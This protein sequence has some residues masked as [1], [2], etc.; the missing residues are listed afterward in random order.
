MDK[1]MVLPLESKDFNTGRCRMDVSAIKLAGLKIN[2]PVCMTVKDWK[3]YC[4]VWPSSCQ[5]FPPQNVLHFDTSVI[6]NTDNFPDSGKLTGC[7]VDLS[8][9]ICRLETCIAKFVEVVVYLRVEN[10]QE[11]APRVLYNKERRASQVKCILQ[12][13]VFIKNSWVC[14]KKMLN[15]GL[16]FTQE[17]DK[18]FIDNIDYSNDKEVGN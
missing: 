10:F 8:R 14:V 6:S 5:Y 13:K 18:I 3:F 4:T 9:D 12:D 7:Y 2:T 1:M 17:I 11:M 16:T 15:C